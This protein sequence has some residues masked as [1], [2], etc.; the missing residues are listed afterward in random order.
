MIGGSSRRRWHGIP[1]PPHPT[2]P[3]SPEVKT[4]WHKYRKWWIALLLFMGIGVVLAVGLAAGLVLSNGKSGHERGKDNPYRSNRKG[5]NSTYPT[6]PDMNISYDPKRD[7]PGPNDG[8]MS[9]CN[10]FTQLNSTS[11]LTQLAVNS[12]YFAHYISTYTFPLNATHNNMTALDHDLYVIARGLA[13]TGTVEIVGSNAP[14][15]VIDGGEEGVV[16]IDVLARYASGED[17]EKVANVCQMTREDGSTGVG[18][19]TPTETDGGTDGPFL[20]NPLLTPAFHVIIRL[21]PSLITAKN[22]TVG[23]LP[24]LSLELAQMGTRIGNLEQVT[25]IGDLRIKAGCRGGGVVVDY[26]SCETCTIM[27]AENTVQGTFNVTESL[28][29]NSTS[30]T[31]LANVILSDPGRPGDES[32]TITSTIP[33]PHGSRRRSLGLHGRTKIVVPSEAKYPGMQNLGADSGPEHLIN[34]TFST[35]E[36]FI[37]VAYLHHP[38]STALRSWVSS[39]SGMV[40]VS[41]HPNYVGPFAL[42]NMWGG[43]RLPPISSPASPDPL[44]QGRTRVVVQG[45]VDLNSTSFNGGMNATEEISA[46]NAVTGA[47]AWAHPGKPP[48]VADVQYGVEGRGSAL[49]AVANLGDLQVTFDGT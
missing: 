2:I 39:Q 48:S 17:L 37:F 8:T 45:A 3:V 40:D 30:G 4:L 14:Q 49:V 12:P 26:A 23:Y 16:K 41:M 35:N 7:G 24:G 44:A 1:I 10:Q 6:T 38:P 25:V 15:G 43:I 27:G 32:A 36:G 47:A 13:A 5:Q 29:I 18:I 20:L 9:N 21:P 31:I 33:M 19:Y 46:P 34:T 22:N 28:Q 11:A 42:E